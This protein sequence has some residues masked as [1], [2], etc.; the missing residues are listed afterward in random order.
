VGGGCS[1]PVVNLMWATLDPIDFILHLVNQF[2]IAARLV[3]NFCEAMTESLASTAVASANVVV[4]Y[5][6]IGR[7]AVYSRH[8]KGS[9]TLP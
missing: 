2:W 8:N 9:R 3:C 5:G 7:C 6:E 4:D 1:F